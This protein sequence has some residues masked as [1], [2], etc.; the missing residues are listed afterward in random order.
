MSALI[1]SCRTSSQTL[2]R[3]SATPVLVAV[4]AL[5]LSFATTAPAHGIEPPFNRGI[6]E[7]CRESVREVDRFVDVAPGTTHAEAISCLLAYGVTQGQF[8]DSD[9]VYNPQGRVTRQQMASFVARMLAQLPGD[10]F[11]LPEARDDAMFDD[12]DDISTAHIISVNQLVDS[13][14]IE[15]FPDGTYRPAEPLNRAQMASFIIRS[16]EEV[17]G[18]DIPRSPIFEDASG[19]HAAH[20]EKLATIGVTVGRDINTYAPDEPVTRSQMA[21]FIA[22]SMDYLAVLGLLQPLA[23]EEGAGAMLGLTEVDVAIREGFDRATF[24]LEGD[25][26]EAGF[27]IQYVDEALA[28]GSGN[29]IEVEG[30]SIIQVMLTGIAIPPD[31]DEDLEDVVTELIFSEIALNGPAIVEIVVGTVF[32][33]QQQVFIGTTGRHGFTVGRASGPQRVFIDVEHP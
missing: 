6:D 17:T 12:S 9:L 22:R 13:G 21:S 30:E 5:V 24:T 23:F 10:V 31:L 15:G 4:T 18:K 11:A 32:E 27:R 3:T 1:S 20:I 2:G 28:Q 25:E 7:A 33:G 26:R 8:I 19:T 16:L 29:L 14:I